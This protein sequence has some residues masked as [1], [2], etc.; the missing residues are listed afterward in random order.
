MRDSNTNIL[1]LIYTNTY[2]REGHTE[3][4]SRAVPMTLIV[5]AHLSILYAASLVSL[6]KIRNS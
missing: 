3:G 5:A 4:L 1:I 6:Q 2:I